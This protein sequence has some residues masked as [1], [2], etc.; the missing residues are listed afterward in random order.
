[1]GIF[2]VSYDN[3]HCS[4]VG[5]T[6]V[7]TGVSIACYADAASLLWRRCPFVC[8][9]VLVTPGLCVK[10]TQ[11]RITKSSLSAPRKTLVSGFLI[12]SINSKE[13]TP[14]ESIK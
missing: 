4:S 13:V 11:A 9:C 12:V 8:V 6:S 14:I 1:M 2:A 10:T 3:F 7:F 5:F